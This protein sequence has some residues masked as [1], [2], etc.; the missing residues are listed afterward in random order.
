MCA[1]ETCILHSFESIWDSQFIPWTLFLFAYYPG[2]FFVIILIMSSMYRAREI[3]RQIT[4]F[5]AFAVSRERKKTPK[6]G[7]TKHEEYSLIDTFINLREKC[8]RQSV[9]R[10]FLAVP[11]HSDSRRL[12]V[13][14]R[15][16]FTILV[17]EYSRTKCSKTIRHWK[18]CLQ[19]FLRLCWR[20]RNVC[21]SHL[22]STVSMYWLSR[23]K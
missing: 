2:V 6:C 12:S 7:H 4:S 18:L 3:S 9:A 15:E 5:I 19:F 20:K 14:K 10:A 17:S 16:L 22:T 1:I 13:N 8:M 23:K 21:N 11:S